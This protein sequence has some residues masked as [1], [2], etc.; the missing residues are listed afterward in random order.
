MIRTQE[1]KD[2]QLY[3]VYI[4]GGL[5]AIVI[6]IITI[7][8]LGEFKNF[9]ALMIVINIPIT[10]WFF[11]ILAYWWWVFLFKGRRDPK[12][13]NK[14]G[15]RLRSLKSWS[16]LF[17]SMMESGGDPEEIDAYEKASRRPLIAWY[18]LQ[19]LLALWVVGNFWVWTLF[20]DKLPGN[21]IKTVWVPGVLIIC[22]VLL[23][24]PVFLFR[25]FGADPQAYLRPLGLFAGKTPLDA[26]SPSELQVFDRKAGT[27][28]AIVIGG[29]RKG[30]DIY[31]E[32]RGKHYFTWVEGKVP[33]FTIR[34]VSGKMEATEDSSPQ[35]RDF[36]KKMPKAKRWKGITVTGDENG[37]QII[38]NSRGTNMW[39]YDLWL[40][41]QLSGN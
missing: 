37:I 5:P 18:G 7:A 27:K 10:I 39:L 23:L 4:W 31:I 3:K 13:P 6:F 8:T 14:R 22:F 25:L 15:G 34:S 29:K 33:P 12:V 24:S 17:D 38:R 40:A 26:F 32:T 35:I 36:A 11:G 9:R 16:I 19:N 28:G 20:Q 21:Y 41:E 30:R 2:Y 1:G